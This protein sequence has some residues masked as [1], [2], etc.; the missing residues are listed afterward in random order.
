MIATVPLCGETLSSTVRF[1]VHK[2]IEA[3]AGAIVKKHGTSTEKAFLFPSHAVAERCV[4]FLHKHISSLARNS[5]RI[6]DL[7]PNDGMASESGVKNDTNGIP[8]LS[9]VVFPRIHVSTAKTFWQHSGD[10]VS[11]RRAEY[12]H[13]ALEDGQLVT[14]HLQ[15]AEINAISDTQPSKGPRRYQ[16]KDVNDQ[17]LT[18]Q[19]KSGAG[20]ER[21]DC[22]RFVEERF[23]RNLDV[24][25]A[26]SA[27]LAIRRRIAGALTANV[28]LQQAL[29]MSQPPTRT[30]D[31]KGFSENDVYLY[32]CGMSAIFN[33][34]RTLMLCRGAMKSVSFG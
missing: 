31:V 21:K 30:Q 1:F 13:K 20:L 28:D 5:V 10:G 23:G 7:F 26:S 29:Q 11:S 8:I 33:T 6:V 27:K 14:V 18:D 3:L 34:H 32:P 25:L 17:R 19:Q 9:A 16:K 4:G 12:C 15:A 2:A 22:A 24:S